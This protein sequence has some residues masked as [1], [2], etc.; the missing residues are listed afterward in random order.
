VRENEDVIFDISA[1]AVLGKSSIE[2][3]GLDI[4]IFSYER[5]DLQWRE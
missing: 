5:I 1:R 2:L 4:S 3:G